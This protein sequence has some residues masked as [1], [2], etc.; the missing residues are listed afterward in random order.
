MMLIVGLGNPGTKYK[1]TR[2]NIGFMA[3]DCLSEA[4]SINLSR[5][6]FKR[7]LSKKDFSSKWAKGSVA[8]KEVILAKP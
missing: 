3:V 7:E 5:Y 6:V 2:H 1:D 4:N 8:G